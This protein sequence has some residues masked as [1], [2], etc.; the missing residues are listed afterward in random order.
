MFVHA[1]LDHIAHVTPGH[2]DRDLWIPRNDKK[3]WRIDIQVKYL[4]QTDSR[5]VFLSRVMGDLHVVH[6]CHRGWKIG[7]FG[8]LLLGSRA[9]LAGVLRGSVVINL[10][11]HYQ[12]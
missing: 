1:D 9:C 7:D 10:E 8:D 12:N 4:G 6:V 5:D 11:L 3:Q 2:A